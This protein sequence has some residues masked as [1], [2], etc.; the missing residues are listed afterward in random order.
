M[1][2]LRGL[3]LAVN[4]RRRLDL[5]QNPKEYYQIRLE[6]ERHSRKFKVKQN[7][8]KVKVKALPFLDHSAGVQQLFKR[9]LKD[10]KDHMQC[11]PNDYLRLN[12]RHPSLES[13]I[14]LSLLRARILMRFSC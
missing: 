8:S 1:K 3:K 9:L 11:R 13:D 2:R 5:L 6:R 14:R 7:V 4:N 12:L 10:V